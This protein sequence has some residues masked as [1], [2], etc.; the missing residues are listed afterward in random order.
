MNFNI[1]QNT[2][3]IIELPDNLTEYRY[4]FGNGAYA[5]QIVEGNPLGSF[6]G[7]KYLGV[8]QNVEETFARDSEGELLLDISGEPV[9]MR[10]GGERVFPGD[11]IG[12]A[13][14]RERV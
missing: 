3:E 5:Y 13:S 12:R 14:C 6:Y 7:Y 8:Y 11:E 4:S 10:N 1:S 9:P 2:N